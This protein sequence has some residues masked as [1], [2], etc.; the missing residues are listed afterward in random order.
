MLDEIV[1]HLRSALPH[2]GCGLLAT[3]DVA[4]GS[5]RA[6]RFYPGD[7]ID[8]SP[9][10]YTMDPGQVLSALDD[11]EACGWRLGAIVH[12]HPTSV[13]EPSVT[14]LREAY[15][16]GVVL[17]IVSF[18]DEPPVARAWLIE[19]RGGSAY[20]LALWVEDADA[21]AHD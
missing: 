10:R 9:V 21:R 2:E 5:R 14:D 3:F 4:D 15:Y 18:T 16:P 7:N 8:R 19:E 17:L 6:V 20:E 11:I 1:A 13:A 12:S